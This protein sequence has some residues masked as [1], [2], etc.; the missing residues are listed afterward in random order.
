MVRRGIA[1]RS[2][3]GGRPTQAYLYDLFKWHLGTVRGGQRGTET[4][5]GSL[6]RV[7]SRNVRDG[8]GIGSVK[9]IKDYPVVGYDN[10]TAVPEKRRELRHVLIC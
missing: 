10:V 1:C 9:Q 5:L 6:G 2:R 3:G 4:E 7:A 8:G